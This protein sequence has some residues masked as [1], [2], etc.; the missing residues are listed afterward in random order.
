MIFLD[1]QDRRPIYEQIA[2]RFRQLI[3][4][5]A[6]EPGSQMPSVR[7]MAAELSINPNTIQKAL[8]S[9][10]AGRI[11]LSGE[12]PGQFCGGE[13][14]S[15]GEEKA[16]EPGETG[17]LSPGGPGAGT[18]KTGMHGGS[19]KDLRGRDSDDRDQRSEKEFWGDT[20]SGRIFLLPS[21]MGN[22][23]AW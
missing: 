19:G 21:G 16:D 18:G 8:R 5:G 14:D 9:S 13:S 6:L 17:R 10:G 4:K 15:P 2:D 11:H 23:S 12:G 3:V 7:Q 22:C 1:Y 20:G